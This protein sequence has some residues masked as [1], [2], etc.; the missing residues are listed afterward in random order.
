[1][2]K[3]TLGSFL[4]ALRR[5]Q[6]LT[7][8][9]VAD[10]LAVSN[11][12][13]SRWERDEAMPDILLLPAIADLFGVTVD[14]LLRGE[15]TRP[16]PP[17]EVFSPA[18][19]AETPA[20]RSEHPN[21]ET[22]SPDPR[23]LRGLRAIMNRTKARFRTC[24]IVSRAITLAGI[25]TMGII[26]YGFY[27]PS[28]GF[29]V[30]LIFLLG[31]IT[32]AILSAMRMRDVIS[33][34]VF[35]EES[36]LPDAE[37][38]IA[39]HAYAAGLYGVIGEAVT[40]ALVTLPLVL[41][42]DRYL[43]NSVLS[44]ESYAPM[45]LAI[46]LGCMAA[47]LCLRP[48]ALRMLCQPWEDVL[49]YEEGSITLPGPMRRRLRYMSLAQLGSSIT[50]LALC[51]IL[52]AT[53]QGYQ[54]Y[55]DAY[56]QVNWTSLVCLAL[57]TVT[58]L[59]APFFFMKSHRRFRESGSAPLP[60]WSMGKVAL[61]SVAVRNLLLAVTVYLTLGFGLSFGSSTIDGITQY[62]QTWDEQ[63]I[64]LGFLIFAAI[65]AGEFPLRKYLMK[66]QKP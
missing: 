3:K 13:V 62:Y 10:R 29:C 24:V 7:Q 36:R 2:D 26:S 37:L 52:N 35:S 20:N 50:G 54:T 22:C 58:C 45:A 64:F 4:S 27:R 42:R 66:K 32:T 47:I 40:A 59:C 55:I 6:G 63:V 46:G 61:T 51:I 1:M 31:S 60:L 34:Q 12:A 30:L 56:T 16:T 41:I 33:E 14:E 44:A 18:A 28:I 57:G 11:K 5:A 53:N 19:S 43:V 48:S 17:Q 23:S 39:C 15:R 38:R 8:Q 21:A 25:F 49:P 9:E 65:L